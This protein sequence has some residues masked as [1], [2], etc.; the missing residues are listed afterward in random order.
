MWS[1]RIVVDGPSPLSEPRF[2]LLG[3][4]VEP[5]RGAT[6]TTQCQQAAAPND[7]GCYV[8]PAEGPVPFYG[9]R[10]GEIMR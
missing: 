9:P 5:E 3:W 4:A 8:V 1:G 6:I 7:A 2:T 10:G